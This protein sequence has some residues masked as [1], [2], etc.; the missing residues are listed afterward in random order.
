MITKSEV[1]GCQVSFEVLQAGAHMQYVPVQ[2]SYGLCVEGQLLGAFEHTFTAGG[3]KPNIA[4]PCFA[5][6]SS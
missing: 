6:C 1:C 3:S 2:T 4:G 5:Q